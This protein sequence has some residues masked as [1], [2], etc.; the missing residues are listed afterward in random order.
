MTWKQIKI[1]EDPDWVEWH[2]EISA[3]DITPCTIKVWQRSDG[4]FYASF[5]YDGTRA[6]RELKAANIEDAKREAEK[7]WTGQ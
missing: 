7:W 4:G 3:K 5:T 6:T 2:K 1:P